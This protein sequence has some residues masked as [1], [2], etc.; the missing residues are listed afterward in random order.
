[1]FNTLLNNK[2]KTKNNKSAS[3]KYINNIIFIVINISITTK[4]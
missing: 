2:S 4:N 3:F 1:M